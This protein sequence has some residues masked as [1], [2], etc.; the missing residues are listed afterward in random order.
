MTGRRKKRGAVYLLCWAKT[1]YKHAGH[2]LGFAYPDDPAHADESILAEVRAALHTRVSCRYLTAEQ[3]AGVA[4]RI[5]QHRAGH[6]ARLTAVI[7]TAGIEFT[8]VRVWAS[9]TE[10]TEKALKDLN[11]RRRLCPLCTPGSQAGTVIT[12]KR[13]RR[14]R[15]RKPVPQA[16]A[17]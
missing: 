15:S 10:G 2:Y 9:G 11:D 5:A 13:Y 7:S 1:P 17:A 14:A 4:A 16:L 12:P 8:I 3:A 6:G